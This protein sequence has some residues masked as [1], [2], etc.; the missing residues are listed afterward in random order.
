[1]SDAI[2]AD[3]VLEDAFAKYAILS[4]MTW[5]LLGVVSVLSVL[6]SDA[7]HASASL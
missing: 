1:M 7:I 4:M 2:A 5:V 6:M 3:H